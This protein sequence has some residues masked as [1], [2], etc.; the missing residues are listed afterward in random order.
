MTVSDSKEAADWFVAEHRNPGE[1]LV[2]R[3]PEHITQHCFWITGI[4]YT[5]QAR[6]WIRDVKERDK[7]RVPWRSYFAPYS[8]DP[9]DMAKRLLIAKRF[10]SRAVENNYRNMAE[11]RG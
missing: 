5:R 11:G 1:P 9:A 6:R 2:V 7:E 10:T 3:C 8:L 4:P